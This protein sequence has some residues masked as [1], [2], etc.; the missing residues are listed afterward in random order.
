MK[1]ES[2]YYY[3]NKNY[4]V[5]KGSVYLSNT[6]RLMATISS[7]ILGRNYDAI[8]ST[9][10]KPIQIKRK[11]ILLKPDRLGTKLYLCNKW[12]VKFMLLPKFSIN[13]KSNYISSI[14][15]LI[16]P[17]DFGLALEDFGVFSKKAL[18]LLFSRE[19]DIWIRGWI[20]EKPKGINLVFAADNNIKG[21]H[22]ALSF[23]D[24][25]KVILRRVM[26]TK[27]QICRG[28]LIRKVSGRYENGILISLSA[29]IKNRKFSKQPL[30]GIYYDDWRGILDIKKLF[31]YAEE[32]ILAKELFDRKL[33]VLSTHSID[34]DIGIL[35]KKCNLISIIEIT[36]S[37]YNKSSFAMSATHGSRIVAKVQTLRVWSIKNKKPSFIIINEKW[38]KLKWVKDFI[39]ECR[40]DKCYVLFTSFNKNWEK[41]V[42]DSVQ[43]LLN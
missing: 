37:C 43:K 10:I 3:K 31:L 38:S 41:G 21:F 8:K 11:F 28:M 36:N 1:T 23:K 32:S 26:E 19:P 27:A 29:A 2:A 5:L 7:R 33:K 4:V 13:F 14:K 25:N 40:K 6:N 22:V 9:R 16:N 24:Q 20:A 42:A 30:V 12:L 34:F 15:Y 39:E 17:K 18:K 35:D